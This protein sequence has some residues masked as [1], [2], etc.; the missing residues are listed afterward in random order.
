MLM[1]HL[2]PDLRSASHWMKQ[3]LANQ[4]HWEVTHLQYGISALL[5]WHCEMS[6]VF[7]CLS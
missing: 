5:W 3:I 2:L 7:S 1:T 4:K 6:A